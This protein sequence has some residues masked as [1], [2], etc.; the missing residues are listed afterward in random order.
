MARERYLR[1]ISEDELRPDPKP[2]QQSWTPKSWLENFWYHHKIGVLVGGFLLIA[3]VILVVSTINRER[4]DYTVVLVTQQPLAAEEV[5]YLERVLAQYGEDVNGDGEVVVQINNLS[6]DTESYENNVANAQALQ[7]QLVTGD[8]L[9]YIYEPM[10][11][12]RLTAVGQDNAHCFLTPLSVQDEGVSENGLSWNWAKHPRRV[13]DVVLHAFPEDLC[14]G[15]RAAV[16]SSEKSA[17]EY[18]QC[19]ALLEAFATDTPRKK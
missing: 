5:T 19:A 9:L 15:L 8:T 13:N 18:A 3:L 1:G 16:T 17:E 6:L 10:Y 2:E 11:E 7:T 14:F 4:P 12:E